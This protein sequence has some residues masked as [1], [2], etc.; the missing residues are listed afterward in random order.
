MDIGSLKQDKCYILLINET[1]RK[2][3]IVKAKTKEG[4]I[5]FKDKCW[6]VLT[7]PV[8]YKNQAFYVVS[9]K[10]LSTFGIELEE[11]EE[12]EELEE[13]ETNPQDNQSFV[14]SGGFSPTGLRKIATN[15]FFK[16]LMSPLYWSRADW[17]KAIGVGFT[18][19]IL[20]KWILLSVFKV[21]LP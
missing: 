15:E 12:G 4:R 5:L 19:Y 10:Q 2:I 3:R 1:S 9:D 21:P 7:D 17:F 11:N 13:K 16:A 14:K 8:F 20:V 18:F 6:L